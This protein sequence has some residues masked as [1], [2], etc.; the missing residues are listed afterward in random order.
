M[1]SNIFY[2]FAF[3]K[4]KTQMDMANSNL[5]ETGS[6][7]QNYYQSIN[8]TYRKLYQKL[9]MLHYPYYKKHDESLEDRQVNL[10]NHCISYIGGLEN[11]NVLE[12]G[13]GNGTQ[14]LYIYENYQPASMTG[15]DIN[16]HNIELAHS[17]NGSHHNLEFMVDDAQQLEKVPD[18]SVDVLL[19]IESA[20][21]Y[22]EKHRF[23]QEVHR[24]VKPGGKFLI[25]DILSRSYQ[26]RG[27]F[28]RW[29]KKMSYHHWTE[30][31]YLE[32]FREN[33][34]NISQKENITEAIKKGYKGYDRWITRTNFNSWMDYIKFKLFIFLQVKINI[35]LLNKRRKYFIFVG[36]PDK[37]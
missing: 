10:T 2:S 3:I 35:L 1:S 22:P 18:D 33:K 37:N 29:K 31:H 12:V 19:C 11:K 7:T 17:I 14:S 15:I 8:K 9:L 13:C 28:E 30:S 32:K 4:I 16:A 27:P 25:A 36:E 6:S 34:L 24:V 26:H 23:M 21:H 20:F 5:L